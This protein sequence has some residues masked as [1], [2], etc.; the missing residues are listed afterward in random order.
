MATGCHRH[1]LLVR[2]PLHGLDDVLMV[3]WAMLLLLL[4]MVID[5]S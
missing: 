4:L 1:M 3:V 5:E 2:Q